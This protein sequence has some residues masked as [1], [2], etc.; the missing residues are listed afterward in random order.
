MSA[1]LQEVKDFIIQTMLDKLAGPAMLSN[2]QKELA[3]QAI[4]LAKSFSMDELKELERQAIEMQNLDTLYPIVENL[5]SM[6]QSV[7]ETGRPFLI[8][9]IAI[10]TNGDDPNKIPPI[11]LFAA[12]GDVTPIT[13]IAQ[14]AGEKEKL[15]AAIGQLNGLIETLSY[16]S[17]DFQSAVQY[18]GGLDYFREVVKEFL[19]E[20]PKF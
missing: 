14:L 7:K 16:A 20:P 1:T 11:A 10:V 19:Q 15:L 9:R 18:H 12:I 4:A 6:L 8:Q 13:R 3:E 5:L 17:V 2:E